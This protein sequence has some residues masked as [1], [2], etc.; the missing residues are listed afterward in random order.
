[1]HTFAR[2]R[3]YGIAIVANAPDVIRR[4]GDG[5]DDTVAID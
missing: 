2:L 5:S 3:G 1:V 4:I